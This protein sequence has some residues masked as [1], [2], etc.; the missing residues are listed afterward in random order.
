MLD[1]IKIRDVK[2]LSAMNLQLLTQAGATAE[3]ASKSS[4]NVNT[5]YTNANPHTHFQP[6]IKSKEKLKKQEGFTAGQSDENN[7]NKQEKCLMM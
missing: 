7:Q 4:N 2:G 3:T 1:E 5:Y 6:E